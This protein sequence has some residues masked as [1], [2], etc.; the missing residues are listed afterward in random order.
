ML[1]VKWIAAAHFL[2][3]RASIAEDRGESYTRKGESS[4]KSD[5]FEKPRVGEAGVVDCRG[6]W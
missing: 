4:A 1:V 3:G 6:P 2:D 5:K